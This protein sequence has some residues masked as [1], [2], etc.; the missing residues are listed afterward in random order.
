MRELKFIELIKN[1]L[2]KSGYIGDDCAY[3][4]ELG[5]VVTHDSLVEE[6]HFS[7]QYATPYQLA[8]KSVV[9]NLS[10]IYASGAIPKYI[11]VSLSLPNYI[12][13]SFVS[14]FYEAINTL[15]TEYDFEVVGG[16]ITGGEKLFISVCA[17]GTTAGRTISSRSNA[18]VGDYIITTGPHGSSAAGLC[19]LQ[20]NLTPHLNLTMSHLMPS[21]Q[22]EFSNELATKVN[23][24][25]AMM[26]T[27][28][29]LVDALFKIANS[30]DVSISVDFNK[31]PYELQIEDVAKFAKIDFRDWI[32]Y[33]GEDYQ[34]VACVSEEVLNTLEV[35]Y[36]LIGRVAE[37]KEDY[38]VEI[39]FEDGSLQI[40]DLEKTFNHF[41]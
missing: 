9:V 28:D 13:E 14:E 26:D 39:V 12:D 11:T 35:P 24:D 41:K 17:I 15:S 37:K 21:V 38:L 20:N 30:S 40:A 18:K 16:D 36:H 34:L 2:S 22:N 3:L 6:V 10:D 1:T 19:L 25:Y 32:F 7:R 23:S 5:I 29:G 31:I 4:K 8:Y 27:S 33:G